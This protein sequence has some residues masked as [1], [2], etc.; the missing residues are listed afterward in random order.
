MKL[1]LIL[2]LLLIPL[3]YAETTFFDNPDDVFIMGNP[4]TGGVIE[5]TTGV[6]T[7]GGCSY[8]WNCTNWS[9]CSSYG[10]QIRNCTNVGTCSSTYKFPAIEQNCTYPAPEIEEK[11]KALENETKKINEKGIISKDRILLYFI[12]ILI[13]LSIIFYLKKDYLKKLLKK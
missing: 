2:F 4:A 10:K 7:G 6:T 3:V 9:E 5:G 12:I 11:D 8:K 1:L 13:I